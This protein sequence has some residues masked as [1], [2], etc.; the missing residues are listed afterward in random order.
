MHLIH[1]INTSAHWCILMCTIAVVLSS[2]GN[3]C[4]QLHIAFP[5][6]YTETPNFLTLILHHW[7]QIDIIISSYDPNKISVRVGSN[8]L[9]EGGTTY[10][11][12]HYIIHENYDESIQS[13][14]IGLVRVHDSIQFND[15][16]QPIPISAEVVPE[17]SELFVTGWG[18]LSQLMRKPSWL[19]MLFVKSISNEECQR[20]IRQMIHH[21][22]TLCT[23][24]EYGEGTCIV[25]F[26]DS[27]L[28]F[29]PIK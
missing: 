11:I 7:L 29:N 4:W 22:T 18:R 3:L 14:D 23:R 1:N 26:I 15:R 21:E 25:E 13:Y 5:S 2:R 10:L 17:Q 28:N 8:S 20:N 24:N 12:D 9:T 27:N 6:K 19:R 16:V